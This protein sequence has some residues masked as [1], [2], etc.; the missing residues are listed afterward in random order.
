MILH[1]K[2]IRKILKSAAIFVIINIIYQTAFPVVSY[3]LTSGP[4]QPEFS[5]FEPVNTTDMVDLFTGSFNYNIPLLDI[6]GYPVNIA[7]HSGITM[8]QEASWVGLGWNINP[9]VINRNVRGLPDDFNGD[10]ITK[11]YNI[12]DNVSAGL[13]GGVS[14]EAFGKTGRLEASLG[15]SYNNY[16]GVSLSFSVNPSINI[17]LGGKSAMTLGL[18]TTVS[19]SDGVSFDPGLSLSYQMEN[20]DKTG[21]KGS[22]HIGIGYN[23]RAGLEKLSYGV[24]YTDIL[25][26]ATNSKGDKFDVDGKGFNGGSSI[27]FATPTF[28]P[29]ITYPMSSDGWN[30]KFTVGLEVEGVNPAVFLGGF[31]S[32]NAQSTRDAISQKAYGY[33]YSENANSDRSS[34]M[35]FNREKDGPYSEDKPNLAVTNSTYDIYSVSGQGIGGMY[36]PYRSEVGHVRDPYVENNGG[37]GSVG[38]EAGFADIVHYGANVTETNSTSTSGDWKDATIF[39]F[40]NTRSN[41]NPDNETYY[42]KQAGEKTE[43]DEN[44]LLKVGGERATSFEMHSGNLTGSLID[45][46]G[47]PVNQSNQPVRRERES[48][49]QEISFLTVKE[50][51][52]G[53]ICINGAKD[54][55]IT[56]EI[57]TY[58]NIQAK[59]GDNCQSVGDPIPLS[60]RMN[61]ESVDRKLSG[62]K[63]DHI[64]EITALRPDG[65]RYVYGIPLYNMEQEE[66]SFS[67]GCDKNGDCNNYDKTN[68]LVN[69]TPQLDNST[70]NK[71]A[72]SH[73]YSK[74]KTPPYAYSYLLTE[75]LSP[76]YVDVT[77]DGITGDDLGKAVKFNYAQWF[78]K[79]VYQ[80]CGNGVVELG[81][82]DRTVYKWRVPYNCAANGKGQANLDEGL[83]ADP[84]DDK[85]SYIYGTKEIWYLH[86][87]ETKNYIAQF[88]TSDRNDGSP[89]KDDNGGYDPNSSLHRLQKLDSIVLYSKSDFYKEV[90][91]ALYH[92]TPVKTVHF[93]YDYSL[94]PQIPNAFGQMA[95]PIGKLTLKKIYFTYGNSRKGELSP[96]LFTYP[97]TDNQ[98]PYGN[99]IYAVRGHDRWSNYAPNNNGGLPLHDWPYVNQEKDNNGAYFADEFAQ[100]WNLQRIDL[101]SGGSINIQYE[102]ND[103]AYVQD[104]K[105][106]QMFKLLGTGYQVDDWKL[107]D[108]R[109]YS[110]NPDPATIFS[111]REPFHYHDYLFF[112]LP[113]QV[114]G[115]DA[116]KNFFDIYLNKQT[117]IYYKCKVHIHNS[118]QE[119]IQGKADL[120]DWG[121]VPDHPDIGYV[122]L[123]DVEAYHVAPVNPIALTTWQFAKV[124]LP[125][126]V[127]QNAN[128]NDNLGMQLVKS[129]AALYTSL[130]QMDD[131]YQWLLNHSYADQIDPASSWIRLNTPPRT[132]SRD[133]NQVQLRGKLGGGTRVKQLYI[134]DNWTAIQENNPNNDHRFPQSSA[135]YG[136]VYDYTTKEGD[137]LISSG[138]AAY[139]PM[140]GNDENPFFDIVSWKKENVGIADDYYNVMK[141]MGES[142]FPAPVVGYSR[143]KV[144]NLVQDANVPGKGFN[145]STFY[146]EKD[147]PT[148]VS[149]TKI[150]DYPETSNPNVLASILGIS[151]SSSYMTAT[152]GYCIELNDMHGKPNGEFAYS[153][154]GDLISSIE[155]Q[156]KTAQVETDPSNNNQN[157]MVTKLDNHVTVID[158]DGSFRNDVEIGIE[159]DVIADTRYHYS[160][161]ETTDQDANLEVIAIPCIPPIIGV[162][163][164]WGGYSSDE[165]KFQSAVLTK[166]INH[167]GLIQQV[168]KNDEGSK[169]VTKNLAYDGKTGEVLVTETYNAYNDPVYTTV[170]PAHW[171]Y[172]GMGQ[173]C[174][175]MGNTWTNIWVDNGIMYGVANLSTYFYP[176]DEVLAKDDNGNIFKFWVFNSGDNWTLIDA[177]GQLA[178]PPG[179]SCTRGA[180]NCTIKIIRSGRRNMATTPIQTIT[181]LNGTGPLSSSPLNF[182]YNTNNTDVLN[183]SATEFSDHWGMFCCANCD[184]YPEYPDATDP[185]Q[186]TSSCYRGAVTNGC[187]CTFGPGSFINP[188]LT[189]VRGIW[190]SKKSLVYYDDRSQNPT[191]NLRTD[192]TFDH[193][194][195]Y[196]KY[197]RGKWGISS[198]QHWTSPSQ[199]TKYSPFGFEIENKDALGIYSSALYGYNNSFPVAVA[200][201]SN[202]NEMGNDNFEDYFLL[203]NYVCDNFNGLRDAPI[204]LHWK[205]EQVLPQLK[206]KEIISGKDHHTGKYALR[207]F[208]ND[209]DN[210]S[211]IYYNADLSVTNQT[212]AFLDYCYQYYLK[213][214]DCIGKFTPEAGSDYLLSIWVKETRN[215]G[216]LVYPDKRAKATV[217]FPGTPTTSFAFTPSGPV[218]EG[219]QKIEGKV[220]IPSSATKISIE[221]NPGGVS[222]T[223]D[224]TFFDDFRFH[225]Y[226]GNMKTFVYD[227]ISLRLMA[228]LDENN[229]ATFYEYDEEGKLARQKKET[230]QGII[231]TK[232]SRLSLKRK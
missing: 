230:T 37:G 115:P 154:K 1:F 40:Q 117:S 189:G 113:Y 27:S 2:K 112:H 52:G 19:S 137:Q 10:K 70:S 54:G 222:G 62:A 95:A 217:S 201:N 120:Q 72:L 231:T 158:P 67:V 134:T 198:D 200:T 195:S 192:G 150:N 143:V 185:S 186:A 99:P 80:S 6:E 211:C 206:I 63:D 77:Q 105:A 147:F 55:L 224:Q 208:T 121:V 188:F 108:H 23:S 109:L 9:G 88:Y 34:L 227:P 159:T 131:L 210:T 191:I 73:F 196:W 156:Y 51:T 114:T 181:T 110:G 157:T 13:N 82:P 140:I 209:L 102:S 53:H 96:Y 44:F 199:V 60:E 180:R 94:C 170:Y 193:F 25:G 56:S 39:K 163:I 142:F 118:A 226:K 179:T 5:S 144:K 15:I 31:F 229:Y 100:A 29:D 103:Y 202:F 116:K 146:T 130:A 169:I 71:R 153:E 151:Q 132:V 129:L 66:V 212:P 216:N 61:S 14:V 12:K 219:W 98:H 197:T 65:T 127:Y 165:T 20:S 177:C 45:D 205:I 128:A 57:K 203:Q 24:S 78:G 155:Y 213:P 48:R 17:G 30:V 49:N 139:E 18:N 148:I 138:V 172:D 101:P 168:T 76:D 89:A 42:F 183:A 194:N 81:P 149:E 35:D 228:T 178:F 74:T 21:S 8:D 87:I 162:A 104:K 91:D 119:Y 171:Y 7:Y 79:S 43:V 22:A 152:Q 207:L 124:N 84:N 92:A 50:A 107:Y 111:S 215:C 64:A 26:Q 86:S 176:G 173:A 221:L 59:Q 11:E 145:V 38:L 123:K 32:T 187:G 214:E 85:G 97:A 204:G 190:R 167:Y 46:K 133:N 33:L 136:Q 223:F 69:Y 4:S 166:V 36:R 75:V 184:P 174:K 141:P 182:T 126:L 16:R 106:M 41:A 135:F 90:K 93:E 58:F 220:S 3:A 164:L 83:L 125:D 122:Q 160:F 47:T 161:T 28:T 225:P 218:I 232:E 175:N 68:A